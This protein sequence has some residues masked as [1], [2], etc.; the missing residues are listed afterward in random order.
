MME[1]QQFHTQLGELARQASELD[2][3]L[4]NFERLRNN[5]NA[6]FDS[7]L[8][9]PNKHYSLSLRDQ[10]QYILGK[11]C[12]TC[13]PR[14]QYSQELDACV[15][16]LPPRRNKLDIVNSM[17]FRWPQVEW[18]TGSRVVLQHEFLVSKA[19][20]DLTPNLGSNGKSA[21]LFKFTNCCVRG[22]SIMYEL[23]THFTYG[24]NTYLDVRGYS[25]KLEGIIGDG[26]TSDVSHPE[27]HGQMS[28]D[29]D[30]H[31]GPDSNWIYKQNGPHPST[32][33][34]IND[35][36]V[37]VTYEFERAIE[38]TRVKMWLADEE[39][40]PRLIIASPVD[41]SKGFL[42]ATPD[43][44][45]AF[46]IELDSSQGDSYAEDQP[47]RWAA[48]RNLVVLRD[49]SGESVLGGRPRR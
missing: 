49:V 19:M 8:S 16:T 36:W 37:R 39:Y 3:R 43:R 4:T 35:R 6:H 47:D 41:S 27:I 30:R 28:G 9:H 10:S 45:D 31:P 18:I 5:P 11:A 26:L 44:V 46:Y 34:A 20:H 25:P 2:V 12:A 14:A 22:G 38:G 13:I 1:F 29:Y 23:R 17:K 32:F 48:F 15:V 42:T 21:A 40:E 24:E 33:Q 7:L